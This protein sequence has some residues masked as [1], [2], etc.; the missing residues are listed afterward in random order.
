MPR[1]R[2]DN[3]G[4]IGINSDLMPPSLP[5]NAWTKGMNVEVMD[6]AVG[7]SLGERRILNLDVRPEFHYAYTDPLGEQYLVIS[8]RDKVYIYR[9]DEGDPTLPPAGSDITPAGFVTQGRISFA[10][11]NGVLIVNSSTSGPY[12][13]SGVWGTDLVALPGWNADW[14]CTSMVAYREHLVALNMTEGANLYPHKIRW[15]SAAGPGEI[16]N[17]WVGSLSNAAGSMILGDT[18]GTITGA[19]VVRDGLWVVKEDSIIPVNWVGGD[20]IMVPSRAIGGVGTPLIHG[21]EE[22]Q[23]GLLILTS[24]DLILFDGVNQRS[25]VQERVKTLLGQI[26]AGGAAERARLDVSSTLNRVI[27]QGV[28]GGR[29]RHTDGLVLAFGTGADSWGHRQLFNG[30][31]FSNA[32]VNLSTAEDNWEDLTETWEDWDVAWA[33]NRYTPSQ[34]IPLAM[35][36]NDADTEWWATALVPFDSSDYAGNP[37]TSMVERRG[38]PI[39]GSD[40]IA[41]VTELWLDLFNETPV[42]V[43]VGAQVTVDAPVRWTP[44]RTIQPGEKARIPVGKRGRY[45]CLSIM[46]RETGFWRLSSMTIDWEHDG[47]R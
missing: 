25:I 12:Y 15:S 35:Q 16:P 11:L 24:Q 21:F 2:V 46:A 6:G 9:V 39:E 29:T 3:L 43:Q 28:L 34:P 22:W 19:C 4:Q 27:V 1:Q 17:E 20:F 40:G 23:G 26:L 38:I 7:L 36:S 37:R 31:G 8:N 14:V 13:W 44:E 41:M 42:V 33:V 18:Q 30:Y 45:V 32:V 5:I 47:E 10:S